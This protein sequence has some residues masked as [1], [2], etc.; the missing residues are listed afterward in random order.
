MT[1]EKLKRDLADLTDEDFELLVFQLVEADEPSAKKLANPDGGADV[2]VPG[3]DGARP[4]VHQV[5]RY[6]QN[7]WW[8]KCEKSL[9]QAVKTHTPAQVTFVFPRD[10]SAALS[11][12]FDSRLRNRHPGVAVDYVG[13]SDLHVLVERHPE[14][15]ARA[16]ERIRNDA[17][18]AAQRQIAQ[19]GQPLETGL[20]FVQRTTE[21]SK[22]ASEQDLYFR[23]QMATGE[24]STFQDPVWDEVPFMTMKAIGGDHVV[25]VDF[26]PREGVEVPPPTWS[27]TD[28]DAGREAFELAREQLARGEEARISDTVVVHAITTPHLL[29]ELGG[30]FPPAEGQGVA[31]VQPS[32][33]TPF[34]LE[35]ETDDGEIVVREFEVRSVLPRTPGNIDFVGLDGQLRVELELRPGADK[36]TRLHFSITASSNSSA[37]ANAAAWVALDAFGRNKKVTLYAPGILPAGGLSETTGGLSEEGTE[38]AHFM[39]QLA[40]DIVTIEERVGQEIPI[41]DQF[42]HEDLVEIANAVQMIES[43][44]GKGTVTRI[45]FIFPPDA[46][47]AHL[48]LLETGS[49]VVKRPVPVKI[50]GG[51]LIIGQGEMHLP[52]MK[53]VDQQP[54]AGHPSAPIRVEVVPATADAEVTFEIE[55]PTTEPPD[56]KGTK[57]EI[58]I[59]S[60]GEIIETLSGKPPTTSS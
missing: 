3:V 24:A 28:N 25:R 51:T 20:D 35:I 49:Y 33:P 4:H 57:V 22:F 46:L 36:M 50:F 40:E 16:F 19:G 11:T 17:L 55:P 32:A 52:P 14:I 26:W 2:V 7:I 29:R 21:L 18:R 45:E 41:P 6:P 42:E 37:R 53:V 39:R 23:Q 13:L 1:L 48:E 60:S 47:A 56:G 34:R 15:A 54:T 5:K 8:N 12:K 59:P 43:G 44:E 38:R 58:V 9:D 30:E 31:I 27:F 10:L